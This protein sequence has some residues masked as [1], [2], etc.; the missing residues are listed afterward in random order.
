MKELLAVALGGSAGA[1]CRYWFNVWAAARFGAL[2]PYGTLIVNVAGCFLIG[3]LLKVLT[4][5]TTLFS[6]YARLLLTTGFLGALTTFSAYSYETISLLERGKFLFAFYNV[7][8]NLLLGFFA[9]WLGICA[10]KVV[11]ELIKR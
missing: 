4:E 6:H 7:A 2:F 5:K 3:F 8:A 10:A 1:V 11:L 9:T